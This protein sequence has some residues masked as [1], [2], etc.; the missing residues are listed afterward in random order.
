VG[1]R[2]TPTW[3]TLRDFNS[4]IKKANSERKKRAVTERGVAGPDLLSM[5]V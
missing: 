4:I 5:R 2:V 3:I 1:K